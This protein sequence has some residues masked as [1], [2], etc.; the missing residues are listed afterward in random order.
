MQN[1]PLSII[2]FEDNDNYTNKDI[3]YRAHKQHYVLRNAKTI[4]YSIE[5]EKQ[6]HNK[7]KERNA[8]SVSCSYNLY[9]LYNIC[10]SGYYKAERKYKFRDF[11][12]FFLFI[13]YIIYRFGIKSQVL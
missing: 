10:T 3:C 9:S 2:E 5:M 6:K 11:F 8:F 12:H 4:I 7:R 13:F 1:L